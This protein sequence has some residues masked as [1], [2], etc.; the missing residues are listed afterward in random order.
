MET[1]TA[2]Q[3]GRSGGA[4]SGRRVLFALA[5]EAIEGILTRSDHT[6]D[7]SDHAYLT[8]DGKWYSV[9]AAVPVEVY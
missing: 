4:Y 5:G 9:P 8:V 7:G 6:T 1:W 2:G 3:I